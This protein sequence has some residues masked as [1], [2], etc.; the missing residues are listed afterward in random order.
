MSNLFGLI[1][2]IGGTRCALPTVGGQFS[3][4]T[5]SAGDILFLGV[6]FSTTID[7]AMPPLSTT[8]LFEAAV[9]AS[10]IASSRPAIMI[11]R[12]QGQ[13]LDPTRLGFVGAALARWFG[14]QLRPARRRCC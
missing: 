6:P 9:P 3:L 5:S 4:E 12:V 14:R 7:G 11:R 10:G 8:Q 1:I 2:T 13:N